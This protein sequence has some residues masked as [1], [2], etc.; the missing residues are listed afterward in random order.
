[1]SKTNE[2]NEINSL[3][4]SKINVAKMTTAGEDFFAVNFE[5]ELS[6]IHEENLNI[7]SVETTNYCEEVDQKHSRTIQ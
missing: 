4:V 2:S 1:M 6:V 7:V 5:D 3:R